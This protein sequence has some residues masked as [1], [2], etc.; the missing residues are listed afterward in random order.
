MPLDSELLDLID[1]ATERWEQDTDMPA[2]VQTFVHSRYCFP[3]TVNLSK[4]PV[5]S[6]TSISYT[7]VD[8]V[9][10]TIDGANYGF[11]KGD[12]LVYWK[13]DGSWP[14]VT[15]SPEAVRITFTAGYLTADTVPRV[16]KRAVILAAGSL[17][18][19][20][21][22]GQEYEEAYQRLVQQSLHPFHAS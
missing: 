7:D 19:I 1:E 15:T 21:A 6:I 9:D 4:R 2:M 22:G 11:R 18:Y 12:Q 20:D 8:G 13:G 17:F 5:Q 10:Q 3:P 16:L 14:A